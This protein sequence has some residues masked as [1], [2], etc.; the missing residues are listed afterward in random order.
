MHYQVL[1]SM[2]NICRNRLLVLLY[3]K[4][5][6]KPWNKYVQI[7]LLYWSSCLSFLVFLDNTDL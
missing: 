3:D 7:Y 4:R 2:G 5:G 1:N 6:G